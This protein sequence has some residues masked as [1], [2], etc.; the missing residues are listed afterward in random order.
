MASVARRRTKFS[1]FELRVCAIA[2]LLFA[3]GSVVAAEDP[4]GLGCDTAEHCLALGAK[5]EHAGNLAEAR[6]ANQIAER[7]FQN[8][9]T[10]RLNLARID[11]REAHYRE[12]CDR[13][14]SLLSPHY[15]LDA[16]A[17]FYWGVALHQLG[18]LHG[19]YRHWAIAHRNPEVA[20]DVEVEFVSDEAARGNWKAAL[21]EITALNPWGRRLE[22]AGLLELI[23]LRHF[24]N[25][26]KARALSAQWRAA[27]P[28]NAAFAAEATLANPPDE[29]KT[30]ETAIT[31]DNVLAIVSPY[32]R[33]A[34]YSDVL[35]LLAGE[36]AGSAFS[37]SAL[38]GYYRAYCLAKSGRPSVAEY[39]A[40]AAKN[41]DLPLPASIT[42]L[43]VLD[44]A[45]KENPNDATAAYL[46]GRLHLELEMSLEAVEDWRR[47]IR[48]G[49]QTAPVYQKLALALG[50]VLH[51]RN[52]ALA[53]IA[54][55]RTRGW[56]S[57]ELDGLEQRMKALPDPALRRKPQPAT[58]AASTPSALAPKPQRPKPDLDK[59]TADQLAKLAFEYLT[60]NDVDSARQAITLE[61]IRGLAENE[62]LRRAYY[63]V[64]LQAALFSARK[65]DCDEIAA[66]IAGLMK[67]DKELAFTKNGGRDLFETPRVL[68]YAG[69]VY[70]LC[71]DTR[72]AAGLWKQAA[73]TGVA[74]DSPEAI[75][76]TFA[77]I[78]LLALA[79]K[80]VK[81]ELEA[82][83]KEADA[84][85]K[86]A[87][88]ANQGP[89]EFRLAM[90]LQ[91][92]G[93]LAES[94]AHFQAAA[95]DV[96]VH[97]LALSGLRDNDL[98]R[99]GVK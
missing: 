71:G 65:K 25:L 96:S 83:Y 50:N 39:R 99:R 41:A 68:F 42:S 62:P 19:A 44:A 52:G 75:F 35:R 47:A 15:A 49:R 9:R 93:R 86:S 84:A 18:D 21:A 40:A 73:K 63:E 26:A 88:E 54:E 59:L 13:Y 37:D 66:N 60:E 61:R 91:A 81:K 67:P 64:Q 72:P 7:R 97:Y 11:V 5:L 23:A 92:L 36:S 38:I 51:D 77:R 4:V 53:A 90:A 98:A 30:A 31:V 12:A 2:P 20:A 34:A 1:A 70:G 43:A 14:Q 33:V 55:A 74:P 24:G 56:T 87:P 28:A 45:L 94:D 69:R 10:F 3:M 78:Q 58:T 85:L 95:R 22:Q 46:R 76:A 6:K 82:V 57:P 89:A 8:E 29:H 48:N 16:E 32:L 17:E 79:G 27:F 80:P